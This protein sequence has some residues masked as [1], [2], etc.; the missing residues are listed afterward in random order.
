MM[1]ELFASDV[2]TIAAPLTGTLNWFLG[3]L[4]PY[5]SSNILKLLKFS[6]FQPSSSQRHSPT[7]KISWVTVKLSGFSQAFQ[8]S[9]P[10]SCSS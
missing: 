8:F 1:G 9:E 6:F 7:S 5:F 3:K 10:F 2:R 4:T